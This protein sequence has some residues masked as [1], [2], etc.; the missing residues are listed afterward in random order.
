V[1]GTVSAAET[2]AAYSV[3][4]STPDNLSVND[5]NVMNGNSSI[6]SGKDGEGH[7]VVKEDSVAA[8]GVWTAYDP[9][10]GDI[11]Y[12]TRPED[13]WTEGYN[14]SNMQW[15]K[16]G[17]GTV[18]YS[19]VT[20]LLLTPANVFPSIGGHSSG[21]YHPDYGPGVNTD[22]VNPS[23]NG[24]YGFNWG[25]NSLVSSYYMNPYAS[26]TLDSETGMGWYSSLLSDL[27][28]IRSPQ[29]EI[30]SVTGGIPTD[31]LGLSVDTDM[32]DFGEFQEAPYSAEDGTP[33]SQEE[34]NAIRNAAV[35]GRV[36]DDSVHLDEAVH[37]K[38]AASLRRSEL[39]KD[40][41]DK[42]LDTLLGLDA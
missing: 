25:Y 15:N 10:S 39:F 17:G 14:A 41:F 6:F 23:F 30:L 29:S 18:P 31:E 1:L 20:S 8:V 33:L 34:L 12:S 5:H 9:D 27:F 28:G 19:T 21:T 16:L 11:Y 4:S 40:S 3:F 32:E 13:F 26:L 42:A 24:I 7:L 36:P 37:E 38:V 35:T 2:Q 22:K